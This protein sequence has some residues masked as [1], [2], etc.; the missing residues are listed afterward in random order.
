[1]VSDWA[2]GRGESLASRQTDHSRHRELPGGKTVPQEGRI[3][4]EKTSAAP[5]A[6]EDRSGASAA[7]GVGN[8][9]PPAPPGTRPDSHRAVPSGYKSHTCPSGCRSFQS[10]RR[11]SD[12]IKVSPP[13]R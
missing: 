6:A 8:R 3:A 12:V 4:V 13:P 2:S 1:M 7:R 9:S 11:L 10:S 5:G